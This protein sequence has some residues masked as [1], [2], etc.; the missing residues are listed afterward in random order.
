VT[1]GDSG[2]RYQVSGIGD[3]VSGIGDQVSGI[4]RERI[5]GPDRRA[6]PPR[7]KPIIFLVV[8][9]TAGNKRPDGVYS[10][11]QSLTTDP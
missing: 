11:G 1:H 2:F 8:P 5:G 4:R 6:S 7:H 10:M 9:E 3:Q